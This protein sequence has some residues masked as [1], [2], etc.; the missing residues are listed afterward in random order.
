MHDLSEKKPPNFYPQE[1]TLIQ[2]TSSAA[3]SSSRVPRSSSDL[4]PES[5]GL[6]PKQRKVLDALHEFPQGAKISEIPKC[7][8]RM[9]T[10]YAATSTSLLPKMQFRSCP[11]QPRA[12]AVRRLCST[13]VHQRLKPSPKSMSLSSACSPACWWTKKT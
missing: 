8:T 3:T 5:L 10:L 2:M 13:F 12:A 11:R 9:S 7:W 6:S 4:F 1:R